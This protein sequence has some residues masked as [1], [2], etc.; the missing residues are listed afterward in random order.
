MEEH[1]A[2][3]HKAVPFYVNQNI[4]L[5]DGH[6]ATEEFNEGDHPRDSDGKFGSGGGSGHGDNATDTG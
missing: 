5:G 4:L 2:E 6:E 1:E 3:L